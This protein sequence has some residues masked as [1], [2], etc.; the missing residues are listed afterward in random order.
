MTPL[1][2]ARRSA[3]VGELARFGAIGGL[4]NVLYFGAL[5]A[6]R[7]AGLAWWLAAGIAY[8]ASMVVY[9]VL[10]RKLTFR[11]AV[12]HRSASMRFLAIASLTLAMN[13][14]LMELLLGKLGMNAAL[15]QGIALVVTTSTSYVGQ[16][17]WA[18]VPHKERAR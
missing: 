11:S 2:S 13:S 1:P 7:Q 8:A 5:Y 14:L 17:F 3:L 18:F 12:S 10:Q 16:K 6:L 9:Y 15:G 4:T